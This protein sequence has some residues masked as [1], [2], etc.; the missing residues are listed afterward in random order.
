VW[1]LEELPARGGM[2]GSTSTQAFEGHSFETEEDL[3]VRETVQNAKDVACNDKVK[4]KIVFRSVTLKGAA[5][6]EFLKAIE[7]R[8]LYGDK[9]LVGRTPKFS[10]L[11]TIHNSEHP[12]RLIYIED[13]NTT[14][15]D[16]RLNDPR[17]NWMRFNLHG[18][19]AKLE[20]EGKIGSYGQG[21]AVLARG[22]VTNTFLVYTAVAPSKGDPSRARLMGHTFQ[23]WY[24]KDG[25]SMSGRGWWCESVTSRHDPVPFT[26]ETAHH[27]AAAA[28]FTLR[29]KGETGT[30]F[31]L[32]GAN[33]GNRLITTKAIRHAQET[34][35]WPSLLN[36]ELDVEL[37]EEGRRVEDPSPRLRID[38]QPYIA[39]KAKLDTGIGDAVDRTFNREHGKQLGRLA[40]TLATEE[41]IFDNPLHPKSPG[42]RRV[43]RMRATSGMITEYKE[44]GTEKRLPF[45]GFFLAHPEID[46]VLK[47]SEPAE[48]DKWSRVNQRL[49]GIRHGSELVK[50]I[51]DRTSAACYGFQRE[52]SE[53]REPP[54]ER[55]PELEGLLGAAFVERGDGVTGR[56]KKKVDRE[57]RQTIIDFPDNSSGRLTPVY[58]RANNQL[59][60]LIRYRLRPGLDRRA[61]VRAAI[62]VNVAED[63]RCERGEPLE[64]E[65]IDQ[66][67]KRTV[68]RGLDAKFKVDLSP[69]KT[70]TF[71]VKSAPY[72]RHQVVLFEEY[73]LRAAE[74]R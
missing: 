37:W 11:R 39:C 73:E 45:V 47:F 54:A 7:L 5:K 25:I 19:A 18:D 14:G 31:L 67:I 46:E 12:L 64:V 42:P 28:G 63:A 69:G 16:G 66:S 10:E 30:S 21:K 38:L 57:L 4:P 1:N 40:L 72:A 59:D 33:P 15:L 61:Q 48:H 68:F 23:R 51:E 71:R 56:P 24:Q 8:D 26:D 55:L 6:R 58:G 2:L 52:H 44:F 34:W 53:A 35:W 32:I 27:R 65:V 60:F 74:E 62:K 17:G 9:E 49:A 20:E 3:L 43:A 29:R 70:K 13:F 50:A 22:A 41:S 36:H